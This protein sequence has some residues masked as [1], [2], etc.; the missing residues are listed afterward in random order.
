MLLHRLPPRPIIAPT[1]AQRPLFADDCSVKHSIMLAMLCHR[2]PLTHYC[3]PVACLMDDVVQTRNIDS[4]LVSC[5]ATVCEV[6]PTF[7]HHR[8][9]VSLYAG[10]VCDTDVSSK[11]ETFSRCWFDVAPASQTVGQHQTDI[12]SVSLRYLLCGPTL[13]HWWSVVWPSPV[14]G[15]FCTKV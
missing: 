3:L 1:M 8:V 10:W 4:M 6:G 2:L 7:E 14:S 11:H 15:G 12:G 9:N 5:R 13:N